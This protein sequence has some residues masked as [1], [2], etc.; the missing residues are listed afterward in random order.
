MISI[1]NLV[2]M[3]RVFVL[4][5]FAALLVLGT[6][7]DLTGTDMTQTATTTQQLTEQAQT[8]PVQGE[9]VLHKEIE[10]DFH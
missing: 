9:E 7:T 3:K 8:T 5:A 2:W 1:N 10:K 4:M 6:I